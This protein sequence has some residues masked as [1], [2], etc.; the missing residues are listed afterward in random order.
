ME[1]ITIKIDDIKEYSNNAKEHPEWQIE[2]IKNSI[3]EFG[4]NDPI[5]IDENNM[6]IEGHG[7][8]LALKELGYD[9]VKVIRLSHL[10]EIQKKAYILAHNKITMNTDFDE[11]KLNAELKELEL[12]DFDLE[13]IGFDFL[14]DIEDEI[15]TLDENEEDNKGKKD[16]L[17]C[18]HCSHV[19]EKKEFLIYYED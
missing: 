6:V 3:K 14:N 5:A 13:K 1:I 10:N 18:P 2:Q 16:K 15:L 9:E 19:A 17:I 4:F 11:D 7:R 12:N 8:L